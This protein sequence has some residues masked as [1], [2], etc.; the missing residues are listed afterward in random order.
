MQDSR[1]TVSVNRA[2]GVQGWRNRHLISNTLPSEALT[3]RQAH[4][5]PGG[6][7]REGLY[8]GR[9][10][11]VRVQRRESELQTKANNDR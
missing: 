5:S 11:N 10:N 9:R 8:M 1:I 6:K 4:Q 2:P 3:V 7:S